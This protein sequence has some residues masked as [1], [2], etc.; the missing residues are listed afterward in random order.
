MSKF[1]QK[2]THPDPGCVIS[3]AHGR[4]FTFL[5]DS[6]EVLPSV[7]VVQHWKESLHPCKLTT[8]M[9]IGLINRCGPGCTTES[10][11]LFESA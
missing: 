4:A 9:T 10:S 8:I 11:E 5:K 6:V 1:S 2:T 7:H 3:A